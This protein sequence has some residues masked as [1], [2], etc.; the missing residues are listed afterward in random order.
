MRGPKTAA[1]NELMRERDEADE[2][3]DDDN[4]KAQRGETRGATWRDL[5]RQIHADTGR[6]EAFLMRSSLW[7]LPLKRAP[8]IAGGHCPSSPTRAAVELLARWSDRV[9]M[10]RRAIS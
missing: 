7:N 6:F 1:R 8:C 10:R 2:A 4:Y 5:K 3:A 9:G